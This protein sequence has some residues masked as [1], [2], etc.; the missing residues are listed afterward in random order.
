MLV[1]FW[2][3]VSIHRILDRLAVGPHTHSHTAHAPHSTL[4]L[5]HTTQHM[6]ECATQTHSTLHLCLCVSVFDGV[7]SCVCLLVYVCLS[8]SMFVRGGRESEGRST[9]ARRRRFAVGASYGTHVWS[10]SVFVHTPA[11]RRSWRGT[12]RSDVL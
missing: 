2:F 4:Y 1:H 5:L 12:L 10:P 9:R 11:V 3:C 7:M 8:L 6:T